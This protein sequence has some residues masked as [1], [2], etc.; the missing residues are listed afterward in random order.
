MAKLKTKIKRIEEI[1]GKENY[2]LTEDEEIKPNTIGEKIK[3][4]KTTKNFSTYE[5]IGT[6]HLLQNIKN[7]DSEILR[8]WNIQQLAEE[9]G[10]K[11]DENSRT[12]R[13]ANV[14]HSKE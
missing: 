8:I 12:C 7:T 5:E 6:N 9:L 3:E 4:L 13:Q 1:V 10:V 11:D 14:F 2:I